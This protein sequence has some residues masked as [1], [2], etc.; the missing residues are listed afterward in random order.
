MFVITG[1]L[2]NGKRFKA[3][4]TATPWHYN[5]WRGT[6]WL[7]LANGKRKKIKEYYN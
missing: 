1:I 2:V 5:I 7:E 4:R 3:I 6:L